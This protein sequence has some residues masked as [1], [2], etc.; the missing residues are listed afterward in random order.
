MLSLHD[1]WMSASVEV[2]LGEN[3]RAILADGAA[4]THEEAV[5]GQY[6]L[7]VNRDAASFVPKGGARS[8]HVL[9]EGAHDA[10]WSST[11]SHDVDR[12]Y[13]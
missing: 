3:W 9:A 2:C 1:E 4:N 8:K 10:V 13:P 7:R 6:L 12:S 11:V 5:I